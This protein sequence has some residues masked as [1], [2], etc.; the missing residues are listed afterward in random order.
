MYSFMIMPYKKGGPYN[1]VMN[2]TLKRFNIRSF[3]GEFWELV[4]EQKPGSQL[5]AALAVALSNLA[6]QGNI[7]QLF[8]ARKTSL[9]TS[10]SPGNMPSNFC[11]S[12]LQ[13]L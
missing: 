11:E 1:I 6:S 5:L 10:A 4:S 3:G 7:S 9:A 8:Q 2:I 12:F 13:L